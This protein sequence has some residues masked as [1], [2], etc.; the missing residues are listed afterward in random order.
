MK[1]AFLAFSLLSALAVPAQNRIPSGTVLP[2]RLETGLNAA[3]IKPGKMIRAD[4]MQDIPGTAIHRGARVFG[5]I[6]SVSPTRL[7]LSFN[8]LVTNGTRIPLKTNL[9]ALASP[10]EIEDAQIP[11]DAA[12]RGLPSALEQTT[13]QVGGEQVYRGAELVVR[14]V[15]TVGK[16][17]PYGVLGKLNS[18]PPCR[19][20]LAENDQPQALWLFSTDACGVYGMDNL[21]V[22]HSG[23]TD[24]VGIIVL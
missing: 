20:D 3:K 11:E 6:V 4:V 1:S 14:G 17:T 10:L 7:E 5:E 19:A 12:D 22:E 24:P 13:R 18:D 21:T 15:T 2:L 8:T 9:R 16:P 23:R